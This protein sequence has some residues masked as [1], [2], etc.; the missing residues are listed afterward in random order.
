LGIH[1]NFAPAI[2]VDYNP[3]NPNIGR[4]KRSYAPDIAEVE[5][6]ACSPAMSRATRASGFA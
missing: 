4:I 5:A 1:Y 2:N 3:D 6:N